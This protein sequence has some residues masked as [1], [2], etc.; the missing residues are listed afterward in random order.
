MCGESSKWSSIKYKQ[1]S[2][3][4][5]N[6]LIKRQISRESSL[7]VVIGAS[8]KFVGVNVMSMS[9]RRGRGS[10]AWASPAPTIHER[11]Q[12]PEELPDAPIM[13]R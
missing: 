8:A 13:V 7:V 12:F 9:Q 2:S 10:R 6:L 1:E 11:S 4:G 3:T 5:E